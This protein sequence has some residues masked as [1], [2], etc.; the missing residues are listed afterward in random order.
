MDLLQLTAP[1]PDA[2]VQAAAG[3]AAAAAVAVAAVA[4]EAAAWTAAVA[5]LSVEL[6][7]LV[8][9]VEELPRMYVARWHWHALPCE[10]TAG[11]ASTEEL[12]D[13]LYRSRKSLTFQVRRGV[14]HDTFSAMH[15]TLRASTHTGCDSLK[16]ARA[17]LSNG[18]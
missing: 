7:Q 18:G 16:A 8:E 2:A 9:L 12:P 14:M 13:C 17:F 11:L 15:A 1:H 5:V 3:A 6:D 10:A 4:L